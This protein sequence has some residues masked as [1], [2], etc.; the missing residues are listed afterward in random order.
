M[1]GKWSKA[2]RAK[3]KAT[4]RA[5]RAGRQRLKHLQAR[6]RRQPGPQGDAIVL[7]RQ[8]QQAATKQLRDGHIKEF[9][10]A[11][12]LSMIALRTLEGR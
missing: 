6:G 8:A 11:H 5:K 3:F 7:L 1:A 10:N 9:D 4:M 2:Q 12:L